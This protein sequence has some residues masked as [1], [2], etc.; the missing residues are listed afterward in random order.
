[1][2]TAEQVVAALSGVRDGEQLGTGKPADEALAKL[3]RQVFPLS[4]HGII[5]HLKLRPRCSARRR[6]TGTSAA[7]SSRGNARGCHAARQAATKEMLKPDL[8]KRL[9]ALRE[10]GSLKISS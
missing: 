9:A 8:P 3:A 7:R 6:R 10:K 5:D 1:M 4:P 2:P